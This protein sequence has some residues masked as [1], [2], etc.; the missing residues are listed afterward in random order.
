MEVKLAASTSAV[1][2]IA[3]RK[4]VIG[5]PFFV[6]EMPNRGCGVQAVQDATNAST[7]AIGL[8]PT[9]ERDSG[10]GERP[11]NGPRGKTGPAVSH[12]SAKTAWEAPRERGTCCPSADV[13]L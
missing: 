10:V 2:K 7:F 12:K 11:P 13:G 9:L 3:F 8:W 6:L 1:G 5:V 4:F